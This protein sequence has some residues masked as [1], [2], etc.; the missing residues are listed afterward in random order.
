MGSEAKTRFF[1][2]M[3]VSEI[4]LPVKVIVSMN[5]IAGGTEVEAKVQDNLGFGSRIGMERKYKDY[6]RGLLD[7]FETY[8]EKENSLP[9]F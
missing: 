5:Q 4:T 9:S 8:L 7:N 2:G 1:G 3:F 6:I